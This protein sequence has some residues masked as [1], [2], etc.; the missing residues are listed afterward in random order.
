MVYLHYKCNITQQWY[1]SQG[2]VLE[3]MVYFCEGE[4]KISAEEIYFMYSV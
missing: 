3:N 2:F 4:V 1:V